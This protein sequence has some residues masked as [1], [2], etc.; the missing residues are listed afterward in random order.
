MITNRRFSRS[1]GFGDQLQAKGAISYLSGEDLED[2]SATVFR[3]RLLGCLSPGPEDLAEGSAS[4]PRVVGF[5]HGFNSDFSDAVAWAER[6][7]KGV[8]ARV[9]GPSVTVGFSWPSEGDVTAYLDDRHMAEE[10]APAVAR[11][12]ED[13]IQVLHRQRCPAELCLIAH[14]M[15]SYVLAEAAHRAWNLR[16]RPSALPL[17]SEII[18]VA[19]DLDAN[20]FEPGHLGEALTVFARRVHVYWS[21]HDRALLASTVKRGGLTGARLGRSGPA[22]FERIPSN[23]VGV[24]ASAWTKIE[25]VSPHSAHFYEPVILKDMAAVVAGQ[26]RSEI[27]GREPAAG[28]GF[29]ISRKDME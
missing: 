17:F 6:V 25:G 10:S 20:T 8:T 27:A 12:I 9:P 1:K 23:V 11:A 15:G 13:A 7:D 3:R 24:D 29:V 5:F 2:R 14:S 4:V 21:R 26:D 18:L 22:H 28:G 16:G 19:P